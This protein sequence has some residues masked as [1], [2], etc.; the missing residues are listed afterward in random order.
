MPVHHL[1]YYG[2]DG[3]TFQLYKIINERKEDGRVKI[4]IHVRRP[5]E[6]FC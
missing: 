1:Y 4:K 2:F 6:L 3:L 5:T